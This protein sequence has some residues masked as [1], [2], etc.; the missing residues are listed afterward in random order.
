MLSMR[1]RLMSVAM[2]LA[3]CLST[4]GL[5]SIN[6]ANAQRARARE[7][8]ERMQEMLSENWN[9]RQ[10]VEN[11]RQWETE[12]PPKTTPVRIHGGVGP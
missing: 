6:A 12:H 4:A 2:L 5:F 1:R 10:I 8:N 11:W 3:I 9:S 7:A